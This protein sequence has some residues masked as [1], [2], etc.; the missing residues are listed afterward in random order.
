MT[1]DRVG[2]L[3]FTLSREFLAIM[4][5]ATEDGVSEATKRLE[6]LGSVVYT[7]NT[8]EVRDGKIL[9]GIACECY[10]VAKAAFEA[11]LLA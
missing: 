5:G 4:L 2:R 11:S 8:V 9:R 6:Q 10:E 3:T 7:G 1:Q